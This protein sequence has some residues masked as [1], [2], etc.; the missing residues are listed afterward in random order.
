MPYRVITIGAFARHPHRP[1]DATRPE[2]L[3]YATT[4]LVVSG[5]LLRGD[6]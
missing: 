2:R 1:M 4:T 3:G 6:S 5:E